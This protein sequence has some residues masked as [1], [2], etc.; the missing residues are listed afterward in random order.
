MMRIKDN[1]S[2]FDSEE[3]QGL[4]GLGMI[5]MRERMRLVNGTLTMTS[6]PLSGTLIEA[7]IPITDGGAASQSAERN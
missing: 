4:S 1:G 5:S 7:R 2:G 6:K 3:N